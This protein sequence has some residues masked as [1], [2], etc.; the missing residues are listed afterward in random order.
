MVA[1]A[2]V[3]SAEATEEVSGTVPVQ[4][5]SDTVRVASDTVRVVLGMAPEVLD[6]V[7]AGAGDTTTITAVA[8]AGGAHGEAGVG[9]AA[10][11]TAAASGALYPYSAS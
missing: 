6:T 11:T 2:A 10:L 9:A 4:V 5:A 7:R 1:V 3:A 8:G